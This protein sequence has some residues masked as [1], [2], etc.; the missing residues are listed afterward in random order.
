M[1]PEG[2]ATDKFF[3]NAGRQPGL[4]GRRKFVPPTKGG[5]AYGPGSGGQTG[6]FHPGKSV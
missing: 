3:N 6:S 4:G 2:S 1:E 5:E